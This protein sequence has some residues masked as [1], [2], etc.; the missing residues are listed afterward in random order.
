MSV[1]LVVQAPLRG[2]NPLWHPITILCSACFRGTSSLQGCCTKISSCR[3]SSTNVPQLGTENGLKFTCTPRRVFVLMLCTQLGLYIHPSIHPG[4]NQWVMQRSRKWEKNVFMLPP[5]QRFMIY[6]WKNLIF[7]MCTFTLCI[8]LSAFFLDSS[9][10]M[11]FG[12][13]DNLVYALFHC[14]C[15]LL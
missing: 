2:S 13:C 4:W 8:V 14:D 6:S 15:C 9:V 5:G 11:F 12:S 1:L 3:A 7:F 10:V